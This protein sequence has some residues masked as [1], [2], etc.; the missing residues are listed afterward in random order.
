MGAMGTWEDTLTEEQKGKLRAWCQAQVDAAPP[1]TAGQF[2]EL[3][4]LL[5][6]DATASDAQRAP[7][8]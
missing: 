5:W 7:A 4:Q 1:M 8:Q 6:P 3:Y 2:T